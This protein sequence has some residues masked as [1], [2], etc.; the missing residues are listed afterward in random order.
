M[1]MY[2][3]SYIYAYALQSNVSEGTAELGAQLL[4]ATAEGSP[5]PRPDL[6][7][8]FG[9]VK[10]LQGLGCFCRGLWRFCEGVY[11]GLFGLYGGSTGFYEA[12][13]GFLK[14]LRGSRKV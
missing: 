11:D 3:H 12:C 9:A 14:V 10:G 13:V 2:T 7:D 5:E 8:S 1:Y 6:G 4:G